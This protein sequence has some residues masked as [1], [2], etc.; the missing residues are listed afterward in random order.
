VRD[1]DDER[2]E[3]ERRDDHLDQAEEDIGTSEM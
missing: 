2:R 3:H 1:A